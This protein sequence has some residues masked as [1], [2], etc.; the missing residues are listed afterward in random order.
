MGWL[1]TGMFPLGAFVPLSKGAETGIPNPSGEGILTE[2]SDFL[3]TE[4]SEYLVTE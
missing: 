2:S 4:S 1:S 3:I